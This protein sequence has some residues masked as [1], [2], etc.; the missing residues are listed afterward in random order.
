MPSTRRAASRIAFF[1]LL[2]LP[3]LSFASGD[4]PTE[5][6]Y[7][8]LRQGKKVGHIRVVWAPSTWEG[9]K[10]VRDTTT[11][12]TATRRNMAGMQ[13]VFRIT[14]TVELE[15]GVDGTF[16]WQRTRTEE[17][18]RIL[19]EET[20][21]TGDGYE[22]TSQV[23]TDD[24]EQPVQ[25]IRIPLSEPVKVDAESFLGERARAGTLREGDAFDLP[26]LN[27]AARRAEPNR[28]TVLGREH[29]EDET[30]RPVECVRVRELNP[31]T[32]GEST[33]W[34]DAQGAL[35]RLEG[36]GG[37]AIRRTTPE[38]AQ[39][40]PTKPAEFAI[41]VPADPVLERI[42]SATRV[43]LDLHLQ[44]DPT[45]RLPEFPDSPWSRI[46]AVEGS[47]EEGWVLKAELTAYERTEASA[48]VPVR[49]DAFARYLEPTALM[50]VDHSQVQETVR[51]VLRGETDA[52]KAAERLARFVYHTLKKQSSD[53]E[54]ADALQ[55]LR[56]CR[57]DCSEHALLYV[58]LCRA[59]GIP[60]RRC[61][62]YVCIGSLW[63]AHA[64]AEI[65]T[66]QWVGADPTTGEVGTG[67]RY[68][69]FGYS[70]GPEP[71]PGVT[72]SRAAGRMRFVVTRLEEGEATYDLGDP[73]KHRIHDREGRRYLHAL[74][75][76][77]AHDVPESWRVVLEDASGM[78]L[79]GPGLRASVVVGADQGQ[80]PDSVDARMRG[81]GVETTF[82]G[83][84]ALLFKQGDVRYYILF[85]RRRVARI[86]IQEGDPENLATLERVLAASFA[87]TP[88]PW[89]AVAEK[90]KD[91][92]EGT[93]GAGGED[94]PGGD[95][96]APKDGDSDR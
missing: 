56:E 44:A 76:L 88:P 2:L 70:D 67:A 90:A 16:W 26:L 33:L 11:F 36:E 57:G 84:P 25:T 34:L 53:V 60:A 89:E 82:A 83:A 37:I 86:A 94:S 85:T 52:R 17:A 6:W 87:P 21:W 40:M 46:V 10:T 28:L 23:V 14:S 47:E 58:T 24:E 8:Q 50:P 1:G 39:L 18:S 4:A 7:E 69:F 68:L 48:Q 15:R 41:T 45:R 12:T 19:R 71:Y 96:E 42:F 29:V 32:G 30:G 31:S 66:G 5:R 74:A 43:H 62:G 78:R 22:L 49:D 80:G 75:G 72:S 93:G 95:R 51:G 55:I 63:G 9:H 35:V 20:R 65:W 27:V 77:E 61:S 73:A 54:Q 79:L 38:T 13:D 92:Q 64:W 59:A 91:P 3:A 81:L